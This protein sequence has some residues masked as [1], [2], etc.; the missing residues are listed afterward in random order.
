MFRI[1]LIFW[2]LTRGLKNILQSLQENVINILKENGYEVDIFIH[3]Y[4][5]SNN[6]YT[7]IRHKVE[8]YKLD[9]EEY[10]LLNPTYAIVD[11]QDEVALK[12]NL[13]QYRSMYDKFNNNYKTNDNHILSLYSQQQITRKFMEVKDQYKFAMF[14]RPDVLYHQKFNVD[15]L[16]KLNSKYIMMPRWGKFGGLNNRFCIC[17]PENAYKYGDILQYLLDYSKKDPIIAENYLK[18]IFTK[19]HPMPRMLINFSFTRM[20]PNGQ[21][22]HFD[23]DMKPY[24]NNDD[25]GIEFEEVVIRK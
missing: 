21:V 14:L 18:Y 3:T 19:I 16:K 23:K 2:G 5:F 8:N 9:F 20:L 15:W 12:I 1:A 17:T 11:N 7:N 6:T 13:N 10:K 24:T 22:L 25:L 4:Y